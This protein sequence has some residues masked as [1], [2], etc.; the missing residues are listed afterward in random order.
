MKSISDGFPDFIFL[1]KWVVNQ[2]EKSK[3]SKYE[4]EGKNIGDKG[5]S[6]WRKGGKEKVKDEPD[7]DEEKY[8][9]CS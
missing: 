8:I 3:E 4:K 9:Y 6:V 5:K 7:D 2:K 1:G